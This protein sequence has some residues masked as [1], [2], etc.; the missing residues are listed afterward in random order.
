[1]FLK[2]FF[3]AAVIALVSVPLSSTNVQAQS[4]ATAKLPALK[5][6][7]VNVDV[8]RAQSTAFAKARTQLEALK[9][10]MGK[11][12]Q[13]EDKALRA[14]KA[15]LTRK[16]TLLSPGKFTE[17]RKKYEQ[18]VA[19]FQRKVQKLQ[20]ALRKAQTGAIGTINR[21]IVSIIS[22]YAERNKVTLVLAEQTTIL[23]AKRLNISAY[24]LK[25]LNKELPS[26]VVER[27]A[28]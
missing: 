27:P 15:E 5:I 18:R 19:T 16:R 17:E 9:T 2:S 23:V 3:T 1:M 14:V 24:V 13:K 6:V 4:V 7:V 12:L 20:K 26:V 10:D 8:V 28:F 21:K 25:R 22:K 11:V